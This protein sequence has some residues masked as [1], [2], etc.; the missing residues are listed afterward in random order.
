MRVVECRHLLR[1]F[2]FRATRENS[3]R[4]NQISRPELPRERA[5]D[6]GADH[7]FHADYRIKCAPRSFRCA[8]FSDSVP[9][10]RECLATDVPAKATQAF[11]SERSRIADPSPE[12]SDF[13]RKRVKNEN[14]SRRLCIELL[15]W[16]T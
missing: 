8:V 2:A 3:I 5:D 10:D 14:Q 12:S 1:S 13:A 15:F 16:S 4:K 11:L 6:S 7:Q 9:N